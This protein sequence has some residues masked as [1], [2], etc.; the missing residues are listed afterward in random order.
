M[1]DDATPELTPIQKTALVLSTLPDDQCVEV[2]KHFPE[3]EVEE[4]CRALM[5]PPEVDERLRTQIL[6]EFS[7]SLVAS[8]GRAPLESVESILARL[9]GVRRSTEI[10]GRLKDPETG[11]DL[12][13]LASSAGPDVVAEELTREAPPVVAFALGEFPTA[14][15]A[16]VLE[17]LPES[18]RTDVFLARARGLKV[19]GP[20]AQRV[21]DGLSAGLLRRRDASPPPDPREIL[22]T[23]DLL[24]QMTAEVSRSVL[25]ALKARDADVGRRVAEALFTFDDLVRLEDKDLQKLLSKIN[26]GDLKLSLRK[27]APAVSEKVYKNM[28]ERMSAA[29]KEDIKNSPPQKLETVLTAQ[30]QIATY[31]RMMIQKGELVLTAA[32]GGGAASAE[33]EALV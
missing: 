33:S 8:E 9:Y 31:V 17:R 21:R 1:A 32:T 25:D 23:A 7:E 15:A 3:E 11:P 4:V 12:A 30:R 24:S 29:L 28:S 6:S 19:K 16:Q 14:F 13:S 18:T 20:M 2:L 27:C 26:A 22:A 5:N 10:V